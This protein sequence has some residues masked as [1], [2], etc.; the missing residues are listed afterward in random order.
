VGGFLGIGGSSTK[1]DR[2]QTLQGYG[3][4]G[5]LFNFGISTAKQGIGAA[6][7]YF[8]KLLSG[9]RTVAQQAIAPEVNQINAASDASK[10]QLATSGT[11]R[12][13]GTAPANQRTSSDVMAQIDNL[14]FGAQGGAAKGLAQ[15]GEAGLEA[16]AKAGQDLTAD[17]IASRVDSYNIN[18]DMQK[19]VA[20][21]ILSIPQLASSAMKFFGF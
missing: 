5:N 2:S 16:G 11:A 15:T 12:G 1:T 14:L 18:A 21:A 7:N 4:L 8:G 19:K 3:D 10:R 6:Q 9:N 13:G 20:N 17:S